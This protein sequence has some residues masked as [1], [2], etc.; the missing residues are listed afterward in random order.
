MDIHDLELLIY[1]N[2]RKKL[3]KKKNSARC[4]YCTNSPNYYL[5]KKLNK[6]PFFKTRPSKTFTFSSK[7]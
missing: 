2:M 4:A 7:S 1:S 6:I 5:T 3:K